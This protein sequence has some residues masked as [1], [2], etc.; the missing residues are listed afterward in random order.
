MLSNKNT[1]NFNADFKAR[2]NPSIEE[3]IQELDTWRTNKK[4]VQEK[5]PDTIWHK[6]I[7]FLWI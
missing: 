3:V 7:L 6:I 2:I 4:T 1:V 5:I